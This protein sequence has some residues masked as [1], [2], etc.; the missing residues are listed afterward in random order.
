MKNVTW[1]YSSKNP[2]SKRR[3]TGVRKVDRYA[4]RAIQRLI[5]NYPAVTRL[6]TH[7]QHMKDML[8]HA[9]VLGTPAKPESAH[10]ELL[11]VMA[12]WL[13]PI[14]NLDAL[15]RG[16]HSLRAKRGSR[17][18]IYQTNEEFN[19]GFDSIRRGIAPHGWRT[20]GT[21]DISDEAGVVRSM[22]VR[23]YH[24]LSSYVVVT[25]QLTVTDTCLDILDRVLATPPYPRLSVFFPWNQPSPYRISFG[26]D[27]LGQIKAEEVEDLLLDVVWDAD[28]VLRHECGPSTFLGE[29]PPGMIPL[30]SVG[31]SGRESW[32]YVGSFWGCLGMNW[33]GVSH[34]QA[35]REKLSFFLP[36]GVYSSDLFRHS[37][38]I[39]AEQSDPQHS[40]KLGATER[41]ALSYMTLPYWN[42]QLAPL[43]AVRPFLWRCE[44]DLATLRRR[45][46]TIASRRGLGKSGLKRYLRAQRDLNRLSLF[47]DRLATEY[48][49]EIVQKT[50]S[51]FP[52]TRPAWKTELENLDLLNY[53]IED[54][55]GWVKRIQDALGNVQ[56]AS[57][58]ELDVRLIISDEGWQRAAFWVSV[59]SLVVAV[60]SIWVAIGALY[61]VETKKVLEHI[62]GALKNW[63]PFGV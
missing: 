61:P 3:V 39:A 9:D 62:W 16:L 2:W 29:G 57:R 19:E 14:E 34:F 20:A 52:K 27:A 7:L 40:G 32:P 47:I 44:S 1:R 59:I 6:N 31:E 10:C 17:G 45:M 35:P 46:F 18:G 15:Q 24:Y 51:D 30:F 43:M 38:C 25:A 42:P 13:V 26:C 22:E 54:T 4:S 28:R 56:T 21:F 49:P 60:L 58:N 41:D 5:E 63:A 53:L 36:T 11:S 50:S 48:D 23:V 12:F 8:D 37:L 55:A 33:G